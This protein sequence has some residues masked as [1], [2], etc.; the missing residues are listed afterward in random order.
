MTVV[1]DTNVILTANR[2]HA[3]VSEAC[4]V[5]CVQRLHEIVTRGRVAI[6]DEYRILNEYKNR[7]TPHIGKRPGDAFVKWLLRNNANPA[8]CD[9]VT[10]QE[11]EER[12]FESFPQDDRLDAFDPA[13]R[14]FVAVAHAHADQPLILQAT[15]SKWIDWAPALRDHGVNVEFLCPGDIR[16]FDDRKKRRKGRER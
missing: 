4:I 11:H 14:K 8:R 15:D 16:T 6:D 7:T 12:G 10:L 3:D 2:Q 9:R 13:D 5:S 1:V